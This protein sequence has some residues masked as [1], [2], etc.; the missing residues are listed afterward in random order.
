MNLSYG[1]LH[2]ATPDRIPEGP[3]EGDAR[4]A[5]PVQHQAEGGGSRTAMLFL[6]V[7]QSFSPEVPKFWGAR[8]DREPVVADEE[9]VGAPS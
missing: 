9:V 2:D 3:I 6:P 4:A 8:C 1:I 7:Q 5:T